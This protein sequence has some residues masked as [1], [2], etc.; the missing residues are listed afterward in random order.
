VAA[1]YLAGAAY[2]QVL[3]SLRGF[4]KVTATELKAIDVKAVARIV[5][6]V[7]KQAADKAEGDIQALTDKLTKARDKEADAAGRVRVAEQ[8]LQDLRTKGKATAAQLAAAE[9]NLAKATRTSGQAQV[10]AAK[11]AKTLESAQRRHKAAVDDLEKSAKQGSAMLA[12][13]WQQGEGIDALSKSFRGA[14][15]N[16]LAFSGSAYRAASATAAIGSAVPAVAG[17]AGALG[18]A[19]GAALLLPG[20]L[21]AGGTAVAALKVGV[22]GLGDAFKAAAEGDAKKLAEATAKL[23]PPARALVDEYVRMQP[24]LDRLRLDVQSRLFAGVAREVRALSGDY[25]PAAHKGLVEMAGAWNVAAAGVVG[26]LKQQQTVADLP[27]IFDRST[28]A[29]GHLTAGTQPLLSALRDIAAVGAMV[30]ADLT[31]GFDTTTQGFAAFIAQARA[32]GQLEAWIRAGLD[33]LQDF[34]VLFSQVGGIINTVFGAAQAEG[35][36]ILGTLIL[37][38]GEIR[39]LLQSTAGTEALSVLFST[40]NQVVKALLPGLQAVAGALFAGIVAIGPQL[41][42]VAMAFSAAAVAVAPLITDL[43]YLA[44]GIL[45]PLVDLLTWLGPALPVVA[46]GFL[47]GAVALKGYAIIATIVRLYQAW[48]AGQLAL[49]VAM[50]LNPIAL[51]VIAVAALVGAFIYLWNNSEGFRNFWI[52]LW[53]SIKQAAVWVWENALKPAFEGIAAAVRWVG[54]AAV[55]LADVAVT[56]WRAIGTAASWLW[57]TILKPVFEGIWL[58]AR[59]AA[60]ILITVFVTPAVVAFKLLAAIGMWL[61]ENV[62]KYVFEA[63]GAAASWLWNN[64][65]SPVI[66]YVIAYVQA[67]GAIFSWL[68]TNAISP[69]LSAI[70]TAFSWLWSNV[71]SPVVD[72]IVAAVKGWGLIFEWLWVSVIQPVGEAIGVA[73]TAVGN[74]FVWAWNNLIKPAWDALGAAISWVWENLI[75]PV[76]DAVKSAVSTVGTAFEV[77][78]NMIK[79]AWDRV[80]DILSTPIKWVIDVVYNNGIRAVWNKVAGLVGLGE[81][82]PINF[83][84]TAAGGG[85]PMRHMAHGGVLPGYAPGVDSVPVLASPGEGWLVPEAVRGLGAGFV[86]WANR[87]FSGGRSDGGVGTGG[88]AGFSQGGVVQR[89][90]DGGIVGNLL[91]WVSGIGD[92]IVNLWKDPVAFIKTKIGST[93]WADL[94]ARAPGKLIDSGSG[95]LW[96]RIKG[97]FGFSNDEAAAA[98][99]AAGG[100]PMGWQQMWNIVRAQFPS[101]TLNSAFRPGDPGYHGKGRAI[102]IGGPMGAI[103]SW[104]A[105]VYPNSTQLIYTPGANILNGRPF[106]YDGPTQADHHDHVHWAFDQG[107]LIPPGYSTVYNGTGRP[108]PVLTDQQW[109]TL[110]SSGGGG[111]RITGELAISGDGLTAY[112]DGRIER[113]DQDSADALLRGTR[114]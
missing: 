89:F 96:G 46:A 9:E 107:G 77:A 51:I 15:Q 70:G 109:N 13:L 2:V 63:I 87:Y 113:Y 95:W 101:A 94:V 106:T 20:V 59:I 27:F 23:A 21:V 112:V 83:G 52:G 60:A 62:L 32:T 12:R 33:T 45:P 81:L 65:L 93:G 38:T 57:N 104:I 24:A 108:E 43:A 31:M 49:N 5:P 103:N 76:F 74:A 90:A 7:D 75:R 34:G 41:P 82:A 44:A 84:G 22:S 11:T 16:A 3:P 68:W 6:Q 39:A 110:A 54:D 102:D 98:A 105:K 47:A 40:L 58:A 30:L 14:R 19:S 29:V 100:S 73:V 56:A 1:R 79:S 17:L 48:V 8:R 55:W 61:W 36:G 92:D 10:E 66:G 72:F 69:A 37:V 88:P 25:L 78:V 35:G 4:Q 67:W 99:G 86:G 71:L 91:N 42:G 53:E 80:Y 18:S 64:V 85:G 97:F 50:S 111:G 28:V 26:F 114:I